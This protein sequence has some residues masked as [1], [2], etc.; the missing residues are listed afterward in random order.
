MEKH[1]FQSFSIICC[2][3]RPFCIRI[4]IDHMRIVSTVASC[5][6]T[7]KPPKH[8]PTPQGGAVKLRRVKNFQEPPNSSSASH[9]HAHI[10]I[11]IHVGRFLDSN[12]KKQFTLFI[13]IYIIIYVEYIYTH[14]SYWCVRILFRGFRMF[15]WESSD[16]REL[17]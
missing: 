5:S 3:N 1:P 9:F 11:Y 8:L 17:G 13:Y 14:T 4:A 2:T 7:A 16:I 6:G 15:P 12:P 10:Y